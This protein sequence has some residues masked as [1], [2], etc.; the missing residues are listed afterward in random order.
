MEEIVRCM[1]CGYCDVEPWGA[2]CNKENA[3]LN[4]VCEEHECDSF[5][6][7]IEKDAIY[8]QLRKALCGKE[9]ATLGEM[10]EAAEQLKH[11]AEPEMRPLTLWQIIDKV[12]SSVGGIPVWIEHKDDTAEK[13]AWSLSGWQ[14]VRGAERCCLIF[15]IGNRI[16]MDNLGKTWRCWPRKPTPEQMAAAEWEE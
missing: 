7:R 2:W 15:G 9:N 12:Y 11:R 5:Y 4:D 10:L 14:S 13:L 3:K 8:N 1:D 6:P 16:D